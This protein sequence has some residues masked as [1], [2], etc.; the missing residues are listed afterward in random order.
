ML[1]LVTRGHLLFVLALSACR[2]PAP[3]TDIP[4]APPGGAAAEA[5]VGGGA[6]DDFDD[7]GRA[8]AARPASTKLDAITIPPRPDWTDRFAYT[9]PDQRR[10]NISRVMSTY[11]LDRAAAVEAQNVYRDLAV[12][13]PDAPLDDLLS[14]AITQVSKGGFED[15]RDLVKLRDA[16]FI[17]AFDLDDTLY[18]QHVPDALVGTCSDFSF[19][20]EGKTRHVKLVPGWE[21]TIRRINALGGAVVIFTANTDERSW[22]NAQQWMLDGVPIVDSPLVS[23]FLTN[24][25]LIQQE[26][27]EGTGA[28]DP[29]KGHPVQEPSKDLR[30]FDETLTRAI[31]VDDNPKRL[32]QFAN[33]RLF[34]KFH[35]ALYCS[36]SDPKVRK[37]YEQAMPQVLAEIEDSLAYMKSHPGVDFAAAYRP[38]T[39]TGQAVVALAIGTL[40]LSPKKAVEWVRAHPDLVDGD[41]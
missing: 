14:A 19:E 7:E 28:G 40:K 5:S 31:I 33:T 9:A 15:K 20:A 41:F 27:S 13:T 26:K 24:S 2:A 18:D 38:Y 34:R 10:F 36:A 16:K 6:D 8:R 3:A 22:A 30:I 23:G 1:P 35:A 21:Q 11:G 32:F 39:M 37:S 29:K 12:A 17:V 4:P 25:H